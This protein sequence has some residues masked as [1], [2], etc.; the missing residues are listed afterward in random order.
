METEDIGW[1]MVS[2]FALTHMFCPS[3]PSLQWCTQKDMILGAPRR[4]DTTARAAAED[5]LSVAPAGCGEA[6]L[7]VQAATRRRAAN[8]AVRQLPGLV[9][10][11]LHWP[12]AT[13]R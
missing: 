8:A 4:S 2:P 10:L 9:P 5:T 12:H 1:G 3:P 13:W 11:G 6:L 7:P